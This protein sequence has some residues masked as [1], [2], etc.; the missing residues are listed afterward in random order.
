V[1]VA[2]ATGKAGLVEFSEKYVFDEEIGEL[3]KKITVKVDDEMT[4]SVP[5][6]RAAKVVVEM[7]NGQ[8]FSKQ[9]NLPKGEPETPLSD[10]ELINKFIALARYAGKDDIVI[11]QIINI[12]RNIEAKHENLYPLL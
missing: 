9:I 4:R 8:I 10:Q 6:K 12:V 11:Q 2:L 5:Q 1:A 7:I 3:T